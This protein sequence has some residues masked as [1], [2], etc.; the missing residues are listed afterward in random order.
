MWDSAA[1]HGEIY[2]AHQ[3]TNFR[4]PRFISAAVTSEEVVKIHISN[5][6]LIK[7]NSASSEVI[8]QSNKSILYRSTE[9]AD[10]TGVS[11]DCF[12]PFMLLFCM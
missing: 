8:F 5:R 2:T 9:R 11:E 3:S 12:S 10:D 1:L 7:D 4:K 6:V